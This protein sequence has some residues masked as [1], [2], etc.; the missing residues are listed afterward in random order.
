MGSICS[1]KNKIHDSI[2]SS[3]SSGHIA[4]FNA[5]GLM[6]AAAMPTVRLTFMCV[7]SSIAKQALWH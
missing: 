1:K 5:A 6:L 4:T 3:N 7:P 2:P